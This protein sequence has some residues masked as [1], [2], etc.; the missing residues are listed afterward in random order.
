MISICE[1][2]A[3]DL[4]YPSSQTQKDRWTVMPFHLSTNGLADRHSI[5][6]PHAIHIHELNLGSILRLAAGFLDLDCLPVI[7]RMVPHS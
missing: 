7:V 4:T 1:G 3:V 6:V 5:E 2:Y